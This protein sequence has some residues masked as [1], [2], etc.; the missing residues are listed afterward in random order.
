VV[1]PPALRV[2]RPTDNLEALLPFYQ[3]GLGLTVLF[4]FLDHD[5]FDGI[6]LGQPGAPYHFEFTRAHGHPVGRAP[7]KDNLL[8]FYLPDRTQWQAAVDR[9][10]SAGFD[11]VPSFNPYWDRN[12]LTFEDPDGYRLV[13]QNA[14]WEC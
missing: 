1:P 3:Q 10:R 11:P 5:G 4:R 12:G 8:V 2:A 13:L 6:M 9:M 14:A 7:T